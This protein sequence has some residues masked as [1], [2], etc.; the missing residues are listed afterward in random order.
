MSHKRALATTLTS[1]TSTLPSKK[2]KVKSTSEQIKSDISTILDTYSISCYPSLDFGKG[3]WTANVLDP[4]KYNTIYQTYYKCMLSAL[5]T[6]NSQLISL[7]T[8]FM[9]LLFDKFLINLP[10]PN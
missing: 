1:N 5:E 10:F 6:H 7:I 9:E 3:E 8:C 4:F 2:R